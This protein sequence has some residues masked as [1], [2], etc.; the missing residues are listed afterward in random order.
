MGDTIL[1]SLAGMKSQ[2]ADMLRIPIAEGE[3][4]KN[5]FLIRPIAGF[6]VHLFSMGLCSI[7]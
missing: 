1:L 5:F 6:P 3:E 4:K 2:G 7:L